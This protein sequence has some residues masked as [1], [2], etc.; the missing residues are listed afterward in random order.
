MSSELVTPVRPA[1]GGSIE[2]LVFKLLQR[3]QVPSWTILCSQYSLLLLA[4]KVSCLAFHVSG[5]VFHVLNRNG[6]QV[7]RRIVLEVA[8]PAN[9]ERYQ[10]YALRSYVED[11]RKLTWCPAPGCDNAVECL[12]D[13]GREPM[14]V[15]CKCGSS[16]CFQCHQ[17][18]HRP[19]R[20][21]LC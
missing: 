18:A 3:M 16:F 13:L 9:V 2:D 4:A 6:N 10:R 14:D 21:G 11:N 1:Y 19:V 5:L 15:A 8:A 12:V 7:P 17:E 20:S